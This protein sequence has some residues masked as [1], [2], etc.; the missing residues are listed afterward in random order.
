AGR[1]RSRALCVGI[2]AYP[3]PNRLSGCVADARNWGAALGALGYQVE[4]LL[5]GQATRENILNHLS[6]LLRGSTAGDSIVFQYAGHGTQ[7]KDL[8][9]DETDGQDEAICP[10]DFASGSFIIDDDFR[11]VFDLTPGGVSVTCFMDC[12]HS[13]TITRLVAG[14]SEANALGVP[15]SKARFLTATPEMERAHEQFR[16]GLGSRAAAPLRGPDSMK[17]VLFSACLPSEVAYETGGSGD[18]TSRAVPVLETGLTNDQF[19]ERV[20]QAFGVPARQHP[21]A[22]YPPGW[23]SRPVLGQG[24]AAAAA[25]GRS[26]EPAPA[27]I[28][29]SLRTIAEWLHAEAYAAP[30][31]APGH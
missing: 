16:R 11:R 10:V 20:V 12:C 28:A 5:D 21:N 31:H 4:F 23:G 18:F 13:G 3:P 1:G 22:D 7:V 30:Q 8:D 14:L 29:Q 25:D 2:N 15:A 27:D 19:L 9:G 6:Q 17:E 24:A 26:F